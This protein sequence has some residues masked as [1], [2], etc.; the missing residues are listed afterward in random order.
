MRIL[1][2]WGPVIGALLLS[3]GVGVQPWV[4]A[5]L[6]FLDPL[7]AAQTAPCCHAYFG[8][9]STLGVFGWAMAAGLCA[10]TAAVLAARG[11]R[12]AG[13]FLAA[14]ALTALL[15]LDDALMIHETVGPRLGVAQ[16]L[17]LA[18]YA[19][20]GVVY[21]WPARRRLFEPGGALL[22]VAIA[23]FGVSLGI[24]VVLSD[25]Q[26][27]VAVVEDAAKFVG[28]TAWLMF[29][30]SIAFNALTAPDALSQ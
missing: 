13:F 2:L 16:N 5:R 29:H 19:V 30:G 3:V 23:G 9:M 4:D 28:I 27:W 25:A 15:G 12:Q 26:A 17:L 8:A 10:L 21:L 22:I 20:L 24:D 1:V 14:L 7:A 11:D 18:V 6:L